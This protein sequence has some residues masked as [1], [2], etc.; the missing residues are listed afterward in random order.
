[1]ASTRYTPAITGT[2]SS[3]AAGS[4]VDIDL[5]IPTNDVDVKQVSIEP[6]VIG[7][8]EDTVVAF[9]K[10]NAARTADTTG[11]GADP[12]GARP[13]C[14]SRFEGDGAFPVHDAGSGPTKGAEGYVCD[15]EDLDA[16]SKLRMR[17][18]NK[19]T[20]SRTFDYSVTVQAVI[21]LI[22]GVAIIDGLRVIY[23][24]NQTSF[25]G[26]LAFGNGLQNLSHTGASEGYNNTAVGID[27]L[28]DN[29]TGYYNT[30]IGHFAMTKN[31]TG[32]Y[33]VAVGQG[34]LHNATTAV[35][36][37]A[38]GVSA[39]YNLTTANYNVAVGLDA[40]QY[41][42]D[43]EDNVAVGKRA[44]FNG[45]GKFNTAIG[46]EARI[47]GAVE[48]AAVTG[49]FN[50]VVGYQAMAAATAGSLNTAV[51]ASAGAAL[52]NSSENTLIG[53]AALLN[54]TA[55][56]FNTVVGGD[57]GRFQADGATPLTGTVSSVYVGYGVRGL[58][59][60]DSNSIVIGS[61]A[62]GIGANT[63]VLGNASIVTTQ[64]T[65][66]VLPRTTNAYTLGNPDKKF[67]SGHFY[68]FIEIGAVPAGDG[69]LRIPY[70]GA[71]TARNAAATSLQ[72]I[73]TGSYGADYIRFGDG[74]ASGWVGMAFSYAGTSPILFTAGDI[75]F[76]HNQAD[77][78]FVVKSDTNAAAFV[79]DGEGNGRVD[80][81]TY[82][83]LHTTDTDGILEGQVWYDQSEDKLKFKTAAGVETVT[84]A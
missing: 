53:R 31:T 65:G 17:I 37:T 36:N 42:T 22:A 21:G 79:V 66:D 8:G 78:N 55:G 24:P 58:N 6:S 77:T 30:A 28:R 73:D 34:A 60:S 9:Y 59:N 15:Y 49:N 54:V 2:S 45:N 81:G 26:S 71:I 62:I 27:A 84:S 16:G 19:G 4:F 10:T 50:T 76:N 1:M 5:T 82:L 25:P 70:Q 63:V 14:T 51:G 52:T 3:V 43:G 39:L 68:N 41:N 38:V 61:G 80:L 46:T 11:L 83:K 29:T 35:N 74:T 20:Q 13:F 33:Q 32:R 12:T 44:L 57:A 40:M 23:V 67:E 47:G 56:N 69:A 18:F 48:G 7:E 64:L 72:L 75:V